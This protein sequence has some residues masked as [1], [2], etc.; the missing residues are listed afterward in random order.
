MS[1]S[2]IKLLNDP[3]LQPH[4]PHVFFMG[5]NK[6]LPLKHFQVELLVF[7]CFFSHYLQPKASY[8]VHFKAQTCPLDQPV[9]CDLPV[10]PS[11]GHRFCCPSPGTLVPVSPVWGSSLINLVSST[12]ARGILAESGK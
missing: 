1:D 6:P 7:V 3:V 12:G 2:V 4:L 9:T 5:N 8:L 10:Q 11:L